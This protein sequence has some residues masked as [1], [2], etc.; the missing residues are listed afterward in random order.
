[1]MYKKFC[2]GPKLFASENHVILWIL[3]YFPL[4]KKLMRYVHVWETGY[5]TLIELSNLIESV[6]SGNAQHV[7]N[8]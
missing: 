6:L 3:S 1:M 5:L 7:K 2:L 4:K 8:V